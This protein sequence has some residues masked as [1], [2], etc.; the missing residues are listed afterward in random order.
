MWILDR[1]SVSLW[2]ID[3]SDLD[4]KNW[5][6][7]LWKTEEMQVAN[8]VA[9]ILRSDFLLLNED[10]E[11]LL[12]S[13]TSEW[14]NSV[15]FL[16]CTATEFDRDLYKKILDIDHIHRIFLRGA[17]KRNKYDSN[18]IINSPLVQRVFVNWDRKDN[19]Q[20]IFNEL[21]RRTS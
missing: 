16:N 5:I 19:L 7:F 14:I 10:N 21:K 11:N 6:I 4:V 18:R 8:S 2:A 3:A 12:N 13:F 1:L 20:N 15:W 17:N 9:S